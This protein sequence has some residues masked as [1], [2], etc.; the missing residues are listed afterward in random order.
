MI[1]AKGWLTCLLYI[2]LFA[3]APFAAVVCG[4]RAGAPTE[5]AQAGAAAGLVAGG[6]GATPCAFSC[7]DESIPA[8]AVW[9]GATIVT[10][11]GI[12]A[13]LGPRL[14]HW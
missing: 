1:V 14:L 12:G 7:P 4:L 9:Y 6:L 11:A 3:I 13:K 10:C 5:L 2:P 8:I